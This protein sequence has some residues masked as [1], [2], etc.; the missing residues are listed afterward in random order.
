M[1]PQQQIAAYRQR[2]ALMRSTRSL[3]PDVRRLVLASIK[4]KQ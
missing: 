3:S 1:T 4:G 2:L